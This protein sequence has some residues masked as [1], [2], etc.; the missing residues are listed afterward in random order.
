MAAIVSAGMSHFGKRDDGI[1]D[2]AAE[3]AGPIVEKFRESIDFA[4]ISNCYSGELAN[5]SGL[6]DLLTTYLAL[7]NLPS[8][9][10]DNTSAS[11][12]A[13]V[14]TA[15]SLID[16]GQAKAVLVTGVEKM[17]GRPTKEIT[18]VITSLLPANERGAGPS[19]PSLAGLLTKLYLRKYPEVK[20]ESIAKVSVKNHENGARNPIAHIKK[21]VSIDDVMGSRIIADPLRLYEFCPVS[22]GS[23]TLLVVSD[24]I[25]DS[26]SSNPVY[27]LGTGIASD[28]S[29]VTERTDLLELAS[30]KKAG[31]IALRR[32]R[33]HSPDFA[34][35][36]D[37]STIL[38]IVESEALGFF[39]PGKG[40]EALENGVTEIGGQFPINT[41]GGLI[42]RGHPIGASGI[43]QICE[44]YL[45]LTD[46]AGARQVKNA[47]S[48]LTLGMA[49][50]G[51]SA[52]SV[53][54]G[55]AP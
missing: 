7:D 12:G 45:Q 42:S 22:D 37:M 19:L 55:G 50:F 26:Y 8:A 3:S 14:L 28:T 34:E 48:G 25:A 10:I 36:H 20:R 5:V 53:V 9:R 40:P 29:Y 16:S 49:G 24:W 2:I 1:L 39:D 15:C 44:A 38:E 21:R 43:A 52:V 17:T 11:G 46:S 32:S 31:E 41:S 18:K 23:A 27:I 54:L 6:N 30:V 35:L 33:I 4:L 47:R 51:N 13:A